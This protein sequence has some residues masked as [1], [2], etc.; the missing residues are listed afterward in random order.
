[1]SWYSNIF[2]TV[3]T[4][5]TTSLQ[6]S[7]PW[8]PHTQPRIPSAPKPQPQNHEVLHPTSAFDQWCES[9]QVPPPANK[10]NMFPIL[11]SILA[12]LYP[13]EY[14]CSVEELTLSTALLLAQMHYRGYNAKD[15]NKALMCLL[16]QIRDRF[17][18]G[19][20]AL[21]SWLIRLA[22]SN[23][24][25]LFTTHTTSPPTTLFTSLVV[26]FDF[27]NQN[28]T[29]LATELNLVRVSEALQLSTLLPDHILP[30]STNF[31]LNTNPNIYL[32]RQT[33]FTTFSPGISTSPVTEHQV[34]RSNHPTNLFPLPELQSRYMDL[35]VHRETENLLSM[36]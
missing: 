20:S 12:S 29:L 13:T 18:I 24:T 31:N 8:S 23:F 3:A 16:P 4:T 27:L 1:M 19:D 10:H 22:S 11:F 21:K 2:T 32:E 7:P 34:N 30:H 15:K 6:N 5:P 26:Y 9:S 14:N 33:S 28:P 17:P 25:T 36:P 35:P